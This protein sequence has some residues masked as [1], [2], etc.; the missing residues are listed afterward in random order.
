MKKLIL[1]LALFCSSLAG[2]CP[3]NSLYPEKQIYILKK[4]LFLETIYSQPF[5]QELFMQALEYCDIHA[6][7]IV[8]HQA[9]LE[10]G[11]FTSELFF[12][13]NNCFGMRHAKIRETTAMGTYKNHAKYYHWFSSVMD[14]KLFQLWYE[15]RGHEMAD[16]LV[17]LKNMNYATDKKYISKLKSISDIT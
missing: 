5:S 9:I 12:V 14:Y 11:N 6:R 10:T 4:H 13:A 2:L 8:Y 17:F 1:L 7:D 15:S 16:Y 3:P